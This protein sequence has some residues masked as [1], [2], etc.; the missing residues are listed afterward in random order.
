MKIFKNQ[1]SNIILIVIILALLI[2]QTRKPL[3]V[4][5]NKVFAFSPE[6]TDEAE[7]EQLSGYNWVLENSNEKR[8]NFSEYQDEVI[9]VNYWATWCPPCIAE[10]PSFQD[11]YQDYKG[12]VQ[13]FFISGEEHETVRNFLK[14]K[15]FSLP[16]FRMLSADPKP[17]DG[18]TLPTTYVIDRQGNIV[19]KKIGSANWNSQSMRNTLDKLLQS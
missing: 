3:Q 14:E 9:V 2:P 15:R 16:T 13:F 12:E 4:F 5:A 7:R 8:V 11:L 10:M 18:Y 17:L 6:V 19:I 1:W